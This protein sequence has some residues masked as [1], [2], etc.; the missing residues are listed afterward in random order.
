[1]KLSKDEAAILG[2]LIDEREMYGLD[3]VKKSGGALKL[4]TIY[5]TLSR[6][7][8]RG[9]A[10]SRREH[11]PALALPRRLYQITSIGARVHRA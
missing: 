10:T 3:M 11:E 7:E 4:G 8:E 2:L 9:F 1:M 5:L 6:M